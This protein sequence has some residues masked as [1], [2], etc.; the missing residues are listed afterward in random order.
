MYEFYFLGTSPAGRPNI[1]LNKTNGGVVSE[2]SA[3][4][5][6]P[7]SIFSQLD[8][9]VGVAFTVY[10]EAVLFPVPWR[11][12]NTPDIYTIVGTPIV[13]LLVAQE[14]MQMEFNN[15]DTPVVINLQVTKVDPD[16]SLFVCTHLHVP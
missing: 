2:G 15:L 3:S 10:E 13:S 1:L 14:Q 8:Q 16:V 5:S 9:H 7:G 6:L 4:G 11:R 12:D